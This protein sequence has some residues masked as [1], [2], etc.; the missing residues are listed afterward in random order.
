MTEKFIRTYKKFDM[1]EVRG[2]LLIYGD[3]SAQCAACQAVDLKLEE[4][5]CP[6]CHAEIKYIAFRNVRS[7]LPKLQKINAQRPGL[8]I[9]DYEDYARELGAMKAKEF[10]K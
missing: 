2:H 1:N 10:L 4:T 9:I 8:H 3:L 7:H 5:A 6:K